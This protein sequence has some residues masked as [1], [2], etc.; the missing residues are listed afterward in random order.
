M[1]EAISAIT[2]IV[3]DIGGAVLAEVGPEND[4]K[5][6][7]PTCGRK[8]PGSIPSFSATPGLAGL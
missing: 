5:A 6:Y 2:K 7:C 8:L 4:K 3:L 1:E